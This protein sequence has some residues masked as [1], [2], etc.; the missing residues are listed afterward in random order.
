[1]RIFRV[2]SD[3]RVFFF[4]I[5]YSYSQGY[6]QHLQQ[7]EKSGKQLAILTFRQYMCIWTHLR[8]A[9]KMTVTGGDFTTCRLLNK[10][11]YSCFLS[12]TSVFMLTDLMPESVYF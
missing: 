10:P 11:Q 7:A 4:K 2:S 12:T 6:I 5:Y 8:T 9:G 3:F 1:M